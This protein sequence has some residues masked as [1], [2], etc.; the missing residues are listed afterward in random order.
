[1]SLWLSRLQMARSARKHVVIMASMI[2]VVIVDVTSTVS[3]L[4]RGW[5]VMERRPCSWS[6]GL[7]CVVYI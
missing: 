4:R 5:P 6:M 2:V 3:W 1:M 7:L